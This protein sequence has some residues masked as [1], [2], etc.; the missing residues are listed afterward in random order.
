MQFYYFILRI[1]PNLKYWIRENFELWILT[2]LHILGIRDLNFFLNVCLSMIKKIY[3]RFISRTT[4]KCFI[5]LQFLLVLN[6]NEFCLY[7]DM[8]HLTGT[9]LCQ[10]F[11][12]FRNSFILRK[13]ALINSKLQVWLV[14]DMN[15]CCSTGGS[16]TLFFPNFC[17]SCT[18]K[19][20][21][22]I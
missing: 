12:N 8:N 5:K 19:I 4:A 9:L 16:V 11:P 14:I 7:F 1:F 6:M 10:L 20:N 18:S 22:R 3:W 2:N 15:R 21:A 17:N 13:N